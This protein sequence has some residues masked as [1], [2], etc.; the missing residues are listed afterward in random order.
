MTKESRIA[1][2]SPPSLPSH[3]SPGSVMF[4]PLGIA[5]LVFSAAVVFP[6]QVS[7]WVSFFLHSQ[8]PL[9][10]LN[11]ILLNMELL[12]LLLLL[13]WLQSFIIPTGSVWFLFSGTDKLYTIDNLVWV[14]FKTIVLLK[15]DKSLQLSDWV[16]GEEGR[17]FVHNYHY[18]HIY[19]IMGF[20]PW[21]P[22]RCITFRSIGL[23]CCRPCAQE[24]NPNLIMITYISFHDH[25]HLQVLWVESSYAWQ[26]Q[27]TLKVASISAD[28]AQFNL[29]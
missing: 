6:K 18:F 22:D 23:S 28:C 9:D 20:L 8:L 25:S 19:R 5:Q 26:P 29:H 3:V 24:R 17:C 11:F 14:D 16:M 2:F 7:F 27:T 12:L 13:Y 21:G 1:E 15:R 10:N 4:F